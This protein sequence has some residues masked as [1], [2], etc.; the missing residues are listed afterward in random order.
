[1]ATLGS[2]LPTS[3]AEPLRVQQRGPHD[4]ERSCATS[5]AY[6]HGYRVFGCVLHTPK[7]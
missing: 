7:A 6:G 1:M 4:A 2:V 3:Q 5:C